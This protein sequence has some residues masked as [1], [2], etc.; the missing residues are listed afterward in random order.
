[1]SDTRLRRTRRT[2]GERG[3]ILVGQ[4]RHRLGRN[5]PRY[6]SFTVPGSR[7]FMSWASHSR[8]ASRVSSSRTGRR[9]CCSSHAEKNVMARP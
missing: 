7:V 6:L 8:T 4:H 1:M 3:E 5:S 2:S 9:P